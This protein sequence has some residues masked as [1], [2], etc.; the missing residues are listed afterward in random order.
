MVKRLTDVCVSSVGLVLAAPWLA[1]GAALVFLRMGTPVL[2]RQQRA[3]RG[4]AP[5]TL[6]KLRTMTGARDSTG[7]LLPDDRRLTSAG[8]WLRRTSIDELPQLWN[9]LKGEMSVVGPR[10]LLTQ[11]VARYSPTERR[12]LEV[13]PGITGWAQINGRNT[14]P[15]E[16]RFEMDVWY[17]DHHSLG[18]DLRIL[19][20]TLAR[21]IQGGEIAAGNHATMPEFMGRTSD[22]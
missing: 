4:G 15:W 1:L 3:G 16:R 5:F 12:R 19:W 8:R 20:L 21:V 13:K 7:Q 18:L 10:P 14:V 22:G 6:Y 2:F 9:V 17:V 11:Y